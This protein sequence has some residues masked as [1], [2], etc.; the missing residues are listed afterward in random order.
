MSPVDGNSRLP[1]I[2][3]DWYPELREAFDAPWFQ[4]L[5]AFLVDERSIHAVYPQGQDIFKAFDRC[6]FAS[7]RVV[8]LG[9]DPYHGPGQAHG[10]SFSVP[11]GVTHPPSLRNIFK[12]I[13]RDLGHPIPMSGDLS[14]WADQGVLLLNASLTVR[15][16]R[17]GSHQGRGWERFTD[18]VIQ[19]LSERRSG[20]VFLLWGRFAQNKENL[21][22]GQRHTVLKAPHPSPLSAHRGFLGCGHFSKVNEILVAQGT[23]PIDW[24]LA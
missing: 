18:R 15:A 8:I 4:E 17:A 6:P 3:E 11:K 13:Q 24:S 1:Q 2:G 14:S 7:V 16:E 22:D 19:R 9:Q 23:P 5:R 12:E 20:L 21:I 10:L